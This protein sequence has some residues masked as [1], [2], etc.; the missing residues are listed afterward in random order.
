MGEYVARHGA[1]ALQ[2]AVSGGQCEFPDGLFYGGVRAAWSNTALRSVLR[3]HGARRRRIG[4]IDFHTGLGP[5][6]HAEKI[7]SGRDV[8]GDLARAKAWWGDDVTSF[9][10]G[11]S[12]SATL[13]GVNYN[14][15]YDECPGVTYAGVALEYGTIPYI[16]TLQ[17]LR[18]D[19]WLINRPD[20][21]GATRAA[22]KR[23]IRDAF[24]GDADDWKSMV[25]LQARVACLAA[26]THLGAQHA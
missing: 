9:L 8:P 16:E 4:W 14:A 5:R 22:I 21:D 6:G 18:A 3:Q 23:Q 13:T 12:T 17:A 1:K 7:Y 2:Q 24:Y 20:A 10:D 25:Y 11:S 15:V 19:Q 26:L